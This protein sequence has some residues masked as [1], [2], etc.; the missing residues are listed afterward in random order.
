MQLRQ[1][2]VHS[3]GTQTITYTGCVN[4]EWSY[5]ECSDTGCSNYSQSGCS[6]H[7]NYSKSSYSQSGY[8]NHS[9]YTNGGCN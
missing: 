6:N 5:G 9:N 7:T 3:N 1:H 8:S 2:A 4:T